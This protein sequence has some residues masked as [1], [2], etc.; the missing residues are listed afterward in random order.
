MI[1][2]RV[3]ALLATVA[4]CPTLG[5]AADLRPDDNA[6]IP[7]GASDTYIVTMTANGQFQPS[8]PGSDKLTGVIYPAIS[9]R[10]ADEPPRFAS[11]DDGFSFSFLDSSK[12]RIGVVGRF[13]SGRY[14]DDDRRLFGL[15]K[16]EWDVELGG[17]VEYWP[18]SWVRTRVELRHGTS[19]GIGF[20]GNAGI[21]FVKRLDRFTFSLGPRMTFADSDYNSTYFGVAPYEAALNGR[22][23]PYKANGGINSLGALGAVSYQWNETW[24]TTAYA[25][26]SRLVSHAGNSPIVRRIG[27]EDQFTIGASLSYSFAWNP[28]FKFL[29]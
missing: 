20:V 19:Q 5:L 25:G 9:F 21:D 18:V 7:R 26:Y 14:L 4:L 13:E 11:P 23:T 22:V 1:K 29:P 10:R 3:A 17:F 27:S 28:P 15:R 16:I 12:L 24:A 8:F 6:P 2:K